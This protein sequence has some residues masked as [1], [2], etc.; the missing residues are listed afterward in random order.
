VLFPDLRNAISNPP[1]R[2]AH[3][4]REDIAIEQESHRHH[5][6]TGSAGKIVDWRKFLIEHRQRRESGQ[7][8]S[9]SRRL[10]KPRECAR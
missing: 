3:D 8:R 2:L 10:N 9:G 1:T 7:E 6:S 4:I 5:R